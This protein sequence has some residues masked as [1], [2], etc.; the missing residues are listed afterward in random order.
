MTTEWI[1]CADRLPDADLCVLIATDDGEVWTGFCERY[2]K[3]KQTVAAPTLPR[4][5]E[6]SA[7]M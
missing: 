3:G 7:N 4:I 2:V 6:K 1:A 5:A